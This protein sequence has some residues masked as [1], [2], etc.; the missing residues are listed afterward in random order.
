VRDNGKKKKFGVELGG[1]AAQFNTKISYPELTI[2]IFP[3]IE[4]TQWV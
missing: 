2:I 1:E 4:S 3:G